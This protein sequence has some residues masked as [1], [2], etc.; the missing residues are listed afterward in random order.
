MRIVV[1][2]VGSSEQSHRFDG[3]YLTRDPQKRHSSSVFM[4]REGFS[5]GKRV[6][7]GNTKLTVSESNH[8]RDLVATL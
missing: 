5:E 2:T 6:K 4:H 1:E 7:I 3:Q 8:D